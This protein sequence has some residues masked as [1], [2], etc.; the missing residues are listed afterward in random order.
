MSTPTPPMRRAGRVVLVA[1]LVPRGLGALHRVV[2]E[3]ARHQRALAVR[4]EPQRDVARRVA[5]RRRLRVHP[6]QPRQHGRVPV[7][8]RWHGQAN[9]RAA[10]VVL[11]RVR[12]RQQ[13]ARHHQQRCSVR[14]GARVAD[15]D[16][17]RWRGRR[18]ASRVR[19]GAGQW[20]PRPALRRPHRPGHQVHP[21]RSRQQ[22]GLR[23]HRRRPGGAGGPRG[24]GRG[25]AA[26]RARA[27]GVAG[28]LGPEAPRPAAP[29]ARGRPAAPTSCSSG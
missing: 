17:Q 7:R 21:S 18:A 23:G 20:H 5:G 10:R 3:V 2:Q 1:G 27:P 14:V 6:L 8:P 9:L 24:A 29:L 13:C 12:V 11:R 19:P 25:P 15:L 4:L 28:P 16:P 22:P 26:P